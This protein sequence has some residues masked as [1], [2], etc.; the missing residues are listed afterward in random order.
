[1]NHINLKMTVQR[2]SEMVASKMDG[3]IVMMSIDN[4]EYYGLD[5]VGSRI[6]E[7]IEKPTLVNAL[8]DNLLGE[9]EV[10]REQ[11]EEDTFAFL[12]QLLEKKLLLIVSC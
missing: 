8:I 11:C 7:L 4:G 2:N 12:N 3:E 10:S 6:W 1:M 5:P 9:F